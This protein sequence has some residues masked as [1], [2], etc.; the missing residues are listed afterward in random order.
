MKDVDARLTGMPDRRRG[1]LRT[2]AGVIP[3]PTRTIRS[4]ALVVLA[5][6]ARR[7]QR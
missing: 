5:A 6:G 1:V 2:I 4:L 3:G 7:V